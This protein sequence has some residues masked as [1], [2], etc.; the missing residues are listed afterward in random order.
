MEPIEIIPIIKREIKRNHFTLVKLAKKLEVEPSSVKGML[1]RST[2]QVQRLVDLS[3]ALNYNFFREIA[4]MLPYAEP[5]YAE[6]KA[7]EAKVEA[8]SEQV[9]TLNERIKGLE[10]E[11]SILRQTLKDVV[12]R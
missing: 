2:L 1:S 8:M 9:K 5:D 3:E 7:A 12:S 4:D 6:T 11:V 10:L